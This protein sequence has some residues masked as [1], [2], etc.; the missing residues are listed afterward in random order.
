MVNDS[1]VLTVSLSPHVVGQQNT[2]WIM[3]SVVLALLPALGVGIYTFGWQALVVVLVVLASAVLT[4]FLVQV[5][6][7]S[8]RPKPALVL[9][10]LHSKQSK[11]SIVDGSA[12]LTGLLLALNLPVGIPLWQAA[13]GGVFAIAVAKMAFGGLGHNPFNPALAGRAFMLASFPVTMTSFAR[14]YD[15]QAMVDGLTAPTILTGV[16]EGLKQGLDLGQILSAAP[17]YFEQF[18][19]NEGGCIGEASA[20]ALLLGGVFLLATK[21]ISWEMP[22]FFLLGLGGLTGM[23]FM[24]DPSQYINPLYHLLSGGAV[25]A[26]FFMITDM[27]T[28]PMSFVGKI[29][30]AFSAGVLTALIRLFGS[31][32]E[33]ASY[34]ILIMNALVPLIDRYSKPSRFGRLKKPLSKELKA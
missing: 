18:L 25:L 33:G 21:V 24:L 2:S 22:F 28:S 34:A 5:L 14:P 8:R 13:L 20:L 26:A 29:I 17:T 32:P 9:R 15:W 10:G 3:W 11:W 19:G 31:Y 23:F 7:F 6:F 12:A 16:K 4:E 30:F 1:A 27:V